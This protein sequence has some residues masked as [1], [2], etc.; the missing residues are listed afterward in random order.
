MKRL[1]LLR[2]QIQAEF[3]VDEDDTL[4]VIASQP[5]VVSANEWP[6][7]IETFEANRIQLEKQLNESPSNQES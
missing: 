7:F 3:A 1:R 2:L 4:S 6:N 5:I